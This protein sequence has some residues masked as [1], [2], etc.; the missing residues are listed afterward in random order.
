MLRKLRLIFSTLR[1]LKPIQVKYQILYRLRKPQNLQEYKSTKASAF[2]YLTFNQYPQVA[3]TYLGQ[4]SFQFLNLKWKFEEHIDW[5]FQRYG[6]LWNYN[7][8]YAQYLLQDDITTVEKLHLLRSLYLSLNEGKI[9]LEPYPVSLRAINIIRLFSKEHLDEPDILE[10]LNGE[11]RFLSERPEYHILGNHLLENGFALV[12]G[13]AFFSEEKWFKQGEAILMAELN[14]QILKDGGHFELSPMYHQIILYRLLEL[15]DWYTHYDCCKDSFLRFLREKAAMMCNW[16]KNIRFENGDIPHF[17]DSAEGISFDTEY[18]L[19]YASELGIEEVAVSLGTSGYRAVNTERYEARIDFA[20]IGA[21]YQ[22]GHA[23]AD[24]LS[25]IMYADKKPI[26][27]EQGTSTYQKNDR[28]AQE[29]S[30]S[31]HNTISVNGMNQ[32]EVW[33]AFRVGR[34]AQVRIIADQDNFF[35]ASHDGYQRFQTIHTRS[36]QFEKNSVL[37]ND[38]LSNGKS[39]TYYLHLHPA[40]RVVKINIEAFLLNGNLELIFAGATRVNLEEYLFST[41]FNKYEKSK[42]FVVEFSDTMQTTILFK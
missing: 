37:I 2:G 36:F 12:M 30:T 13:G 42:R 35:E 31:A 6:K 17:N 39:G 38:H 11:L 32:S 14:E 40:V 23:H 19:K 41:G 34:R 3:P 21:S 5:N 27:I 33:D 22:P 9:G 4:N 25:F 28:R 20:Q 26:F 10:N 24:A 18:L 16:L 7:L 29:R 15:I 1:Y 8:Q